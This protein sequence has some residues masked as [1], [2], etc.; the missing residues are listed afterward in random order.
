MAEDDLRTADLQR[1]SPHWKEYKNSF[2]LCS[3]SGVPSGHCTLFGQAHRTDLYEEFGRSG[4]CICQ[5]Y[6]FQWCL[7]KTGKKFINR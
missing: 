6:D 7:K 2:F 5:R 3:P 1:V 4:Q